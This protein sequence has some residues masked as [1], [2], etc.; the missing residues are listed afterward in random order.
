MS[1][2]G[3][4]CNYIESDDTDDLREEMAAVGHG[5]PIIPIVAC[6]TTCVRIEPESKFV[7]I[8]Y[9]SSNELLMPLVLPTPTN[10]LYIVL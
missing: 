8:E 4:L 2:N 10:I 5:E 7:Y 9:S 1:P 3:Y 6:E